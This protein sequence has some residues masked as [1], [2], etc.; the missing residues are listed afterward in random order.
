MLLLATSQRG[1][2]SFAAND[3]GT[4][5]AV[6]VDANG[7]EEP[8]TVAL[9]RFGVTHQVTAFIRRV[10][11]PPAV[12][13][14]RD[15]W[16][17]RG[18]NGVTSGGQFALP[19]GYTESSDPV[20]VASARGQVYAVGRVMNR[21]AV[22]NSSTNPASIRVWQSG[23]GGATFPGTGSEVDM[24][25]AGA[26]RTVD[27]PWIAV[28]P[29]GT[30]YVAWVRADLTGNGQSQILFRRSR[31]G[32]AKA[33]VCCGRSATWDDVVAVST[34][35]DV[36]GPQIVIDSAGFVSVKPHAGQV[37]VM[38]CADQRRRTAHASADVRRHRAAAMVGQLKPR[39]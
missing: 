38:F 31:T 35:G 1:D 18:S 11:V 4:P 12:F 10:S 19:A 29:G 26:T 36:T 23:D 39:I 17:Y 25:P 6:A 5:T 9:A 14:V 21:D 33:H 34:P 7:V 28:S 13:H 22:D 15:E 32:V 16:V 2:S 8:T 30:V 3:L 20:L 37:N 24:L 27:K